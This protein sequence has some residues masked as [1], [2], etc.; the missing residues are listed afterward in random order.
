M[1]TSRLGA[2]TLFFDCQFRFDRLPS[3]RIGSPH[4]VLKL[5][6]AAIVVATI[7]F[8]FDVGAGTETAVVRQANFFIF[9]LVDDLV[10]N[11]H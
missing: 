6:G 10:T 3:G 8:E 2:G 1:L 4:C 5:I 7:E 11:S 9:C